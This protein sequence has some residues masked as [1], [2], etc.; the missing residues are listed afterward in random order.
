MGPFAPYSAS[1]RR[2]SFA[3]AARFA[4]PRGGIGRPKSRS[5][6]ARIASTCGIRSAC[7]GSRDL[8][9][10]VRAAAA[11][12]V[13]LLHYRHVR[14]PALMR[15]VPHEL[16]ADV[17]RLQRRQR[18]AVAPREGR[19]RDA[20]QQRARLGFHRWP[21]RLARR[22][23]KMPELRDLQGQRPQLLDHGTRPKQERL[24][25]RGRGSAGLHPG[26]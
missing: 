13:E 15:L 23:R 11:E 12:A 8:F 16:P 18:H 2:S 26:K 25:H 6:A 24:D 9:R 5:Y 7:A 22:F 10:F 17:V 3:P 14:E 20:F 21:S 19:R 1:L 4:S